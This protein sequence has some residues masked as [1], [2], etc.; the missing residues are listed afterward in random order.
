MKITKRQLKQI[1]RKTL[2]EGAYEKLNADVTGD[3]ANLDQEL[4]FGL[5][6]EVEALCEKYATRYAQY[7]VSAADVME[8]LKTVIREIE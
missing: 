8:E 1:V 7:G 6:E 4:Y 3:S 5:A 2:R